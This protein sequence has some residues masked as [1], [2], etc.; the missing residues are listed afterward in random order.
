MD[1]Y[2]CFVLVCIVSN[3]KHHLLFLFR[4]IP[5]IPIGI[6]TTFKQSHLLHFFFYFLSPQETN[7]RGTRSGTASRQ[8]IDA[9]AAGRSTQQ[10]LRPTATIGGSTF[11]HHARCTAGRPPRTAAMGRG[12]YGRVLKRVL[13]FTT[14]KPVQHRNKSRYIMLGICRSSV[15]I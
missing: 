1:V 8:P 9:V 2:A 13:S 6:I 10:R 7:R 4:I 3:A 5:I 14:T 12:A 11:R 15:V